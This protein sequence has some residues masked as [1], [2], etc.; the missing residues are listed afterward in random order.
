MAA[1]KIAPALLK[2]WAAMAPLPDTNS[3]RPGRP[4]LRDGVMDAHVY[5]AWAPWG[6]R[7]IPQVVHLRLAACDAANSLAAW[8]DG[9]LPFAPESSY[10]RPEDLK[11]LV[12]AAQAAVSGR[13]ERDV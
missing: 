3:G 10:G 9:V 1:M 13:S 11:R 12:A 7:L 6:I 2:K 4:G 8:R 5:Q